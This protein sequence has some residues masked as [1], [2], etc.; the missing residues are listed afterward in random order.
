MKSSVDYAQAVL[1][2]YPDADVIEASPECLV[3]PCYASGGGY[4][5]IGRGADR[6]AAWLDAYRRILPRFAT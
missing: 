5:V 6:D 3:I 4:T 2:K 1:N